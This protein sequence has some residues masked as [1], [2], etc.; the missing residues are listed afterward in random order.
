MDPSA[1]RV[2]FAVGWIFPGI[3]AIGL[4]FLPESPYY[5]VLKNRRDDAY[6]SLL[7]L[8][9]PHEDIEGRIAQ[10]EATVEAER[11]MAAE[12]ASYMDCFR[13]T[14]ARRTGIILICMYMPQV[15]G[16]VLS[17][18]APYFL[19]QTGLASQTVIMLVQIGISMGV[20]SA[21]LN[22][23]LMMKFGRRPLMFFGVGLCCLMYLIMGIGGVL[24]RSNSSLL[25]IG[26][27]L[28]FTSI[29]YGP[30]IGATMAVAGEV[31]S[32][33][34]RAKSVGIGTAFM[35]VTSTIWTIV[36]P[37][38]FNQD[39]ANLGGNIGWIFFGMALVMLVVM[40]FCIPETKGRS[41]EELDIMFQKKI[42]TRAFKRFELEGTEVLE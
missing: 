25:A 3:L 8:S 22:V 34:L 31:S 29:S 9:G 42:P 40:F 15:V 30:A 19:S 23:F 26:V 5:F 27:A 17:S 24:P 20:A 1:F 32:S 18:N 10:I 33:R 38:L 39:Q 11:R 37:Y 4:P 7:R 21:L 13:G 14:N 16:A 6:H 28:Q 36:M 41:F 35:Y 12:S 2:L